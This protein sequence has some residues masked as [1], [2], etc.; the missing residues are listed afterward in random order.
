MIQWTSATAE[1]PMPRRLKFSMNRKST[2]S[3]IFSS[4]GAILQSRMGIPLFHNHLAVD[5]VRTLFEF[6]TDSFIRLREEIWMSSFS[7]AARAGRSFIFTASRL[8]RA[9]RPVA[10]IRA[11]RPRPEERGA[12]WSGRAG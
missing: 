5:L 1:A 8:K 12:R 10:S 9:S 11:T 3:Q 2:T 6:G 4:I 7:E